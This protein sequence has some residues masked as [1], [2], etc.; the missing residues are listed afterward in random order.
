MGS[1]RWGTS[2][3]PG[4]TYSYMVIATFS[5]DESRLLIFCITFNGFRLVSVLMGLKLTLE[6]RIWFYRYYAYMTQTLYP[7]LD[8]VCMV[9]NSPV[10]YYGPL[11]P[12]DDVQTLLQTTKPY[13]QNGETHCHSWRHCGFYD[14]IYLLKVWSY[15]EIFL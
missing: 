2:D 6:T 8:W 11:F 9:R 12:D 4:H 5:S 14:C 7:G 13:W 3:W 15:I 1:S 10:Y